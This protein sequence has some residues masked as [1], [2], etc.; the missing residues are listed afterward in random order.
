MNRKI[1]I[2]SAFRRAEA[3]DSN[4]VRTLAELLCDENFFVRRKALANE[5][6]PTDVVDLLVRTGASADLRGKGA[7]DPDVSL[8][9]LERLAALGAFGRELVAA[10]P[11]ASEQL[12]ER[13][14]SEGPRSVTVIILKHPNCPVKLLEAACVSMDAEERRLA[15]MHPRTPADLIRDLRRAGADLQLQSVRPPEEPLPIEVIERLAALRQCGCVIAAV[16]RNCPPTLLESIAQDE[17]WRVRLA[18][19][20]NPHTPTSALEHLLSID[21]EQVRVRLLEHPNVP[22][23]VVMEA[24]EHPHLEVRIAAARHAK[25]PAEALTMLAADGAYQVREIVARHPQVPREAINQLRRLG[26]AEDLLNFTEPD[27]ELSASAISELVRLGVWPRRLAARHPNTDAAT[28]QTLACDADHV[29]REWAARHSNLPAEFLE[30]LERVGTSRDLLGMLPPDPSLRPSEL[31]SIASFGPWAA[32][33][34]AQHPNATE[35]LLAEFAKS[36]DATLRT[37]AASHVNTPCESLCVLARDDVPDVRFAV[38]SH[39]RISDVDAAQLATDSISG[40]RFAL[41]Q[42]RATGDDIIA[43]LETDLNADIAAAA[44]AR[45]GAESPRIDPGT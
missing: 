35:S 21:D 2:S 7:V 18:V 17:D 23:R 12:L 10:H 9:E 38:A 15:A 41:I 27:L 45:R 43:M 33:L 11:N 14:A 31:E 36:E 32:R 1:D 25:A 40:I 34:V 30:L 19:L 3:G 16:Q 26:S 29:V 44:K 6:A 5:R 4:D 42:N 24:A 37:A 39:P 8:G 28:L 20:Q 13:V 22:P